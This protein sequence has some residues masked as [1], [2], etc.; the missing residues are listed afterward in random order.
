MVMYAARPILKST[1]VDRRLEYFFGHGR[2]LRREADV[3]PACGPDIV[4]SCALRRIRMEQ[5]VTNVGL[6]EAATRLTIRILGRTHGAKAAWL[7]AEA[8]P[9]FETRRSG[10]LSRA[11]G[12]RNPAD[13]RPAARE[14]WRCGRQRGGAE[15][16]AA[17]GRGVNSVARHRNAWVPASSARPFAS[18]RPTGPPRSDRNAA[19]D[20]GQPDG[21]GA[22]RS[23][24][25]A[26][27]GQ[28]TVV[29]VAR[30]YERKRRW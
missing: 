10:L 29:G 22:R 12:R 4:R 26:A 30:G 17:R 9:R 20:D 1:A 27:G 11:R 13:R 21:H 28:R 19:A 2:D 15:L 24:R 14:E 7:R 23:R 3:E 5:K 25:G 8:N 16:R 6:R 18:A